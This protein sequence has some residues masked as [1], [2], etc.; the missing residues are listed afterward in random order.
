VHYRLGKAYGINYVPS[1]W[2]AFRATN[3]DTV[4]YCQPDGLLFVEEGG[5]KLVICEVKYQHVPDAFF[6]LQDKYLPVV[7]AAFPTIPLALCEVVK[8]YDPAVAFPCEVKKAPRV[9]EVK[10]NEF[11]VHILNR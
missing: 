2:F 10:E 1:L 11:G 6:Q 5:E 4:Q 8:W 7:Q 9:H 3:S